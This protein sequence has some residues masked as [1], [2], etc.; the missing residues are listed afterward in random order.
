MKTPDKS[1]WPKKGHPFHWTECYFAPGDKIKWCQN[2]TGTLKSG[3]VQRVRRNKFGRI[4][5]YA[6]RQIEAILIEDVAW[7]ESSQPRECVR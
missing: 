1:P 3:I 5:Y 7:A 2:K 6:A 4:S